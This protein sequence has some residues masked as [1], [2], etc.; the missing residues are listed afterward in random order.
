MRTKRSLQMLTLISTCAVF[1]CSPGA[2]FGRTLYVDDDAPGPRDGSTW[3][4]A[5]QRLQD[6][7]TCAS[8]SDEI[9]IAQ[10]VYQPD[11]G[12]GNAA[13]DHNATFR[14]PDGVTIRGGFAGAAGPDPDLRDPANFAT[15]LTGDLAGDGDPNGGTT[16]L[17]NS[18][19]VVTAKNVSSGVVLDGLTIA[20]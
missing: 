7:L 2:V 19:H 14:V 15:I 6:A 1:L 16:F 18:S 4:T 13:G 8:A 9:R 20:Q 5:F 11:R 3:T 10:G 17:D 12:G